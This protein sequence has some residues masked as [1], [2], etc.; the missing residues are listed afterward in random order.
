M[1]PDTSR[2][3][4]SWGLPLCREQLTTG[5]RAQSTG[6]ESRWDKLKSKKHMLFI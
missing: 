5:I 3:Q 2:A 6:E 4:A 1:L